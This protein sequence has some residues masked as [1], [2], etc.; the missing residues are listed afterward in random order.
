MLAGVLVGYNDDQLADLAVLHPLVELRHDLL[1]VG[2]DLVVGGHEHIEAIFLDSVCGFYSYAVKS[3]AGYTPLWN[4]CDVVSV[5]GLDGI[6]C[7]ISRRVY[8]ST[9]SVQYATSF[10]LPLRDSLWTLDLSFSA[11]AGGILMAVAVDQL[12][13]LD[14]KKRAHRDGDEQ[15]A[16]HDLAHS[17]DR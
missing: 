15:N 7:R 9:K 3:S 10:A 8:T 1:D 2:F 4:L 16:L 12:A 11:V 13:W 14:R 17:A 5:P 6:E